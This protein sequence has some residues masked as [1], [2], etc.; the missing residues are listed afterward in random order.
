MEAVIKTHVG[1]MREVN[2]DSGDILYADDNNI[3]L[4]VVADGMGGHQA[5]DVASQMVLEGIKD[6]FQTVDK[7]QSIEAWERW[8]RET[9][10]ATNRHIYEYAQEN[11]LY[12]GMGTTV[13]A[14]LFAEHQFLVAHVGDSRLYRYTDHLEVVT[15]DHSLVH[16]LVQSG[17]ISKEEAELHPQ[18]NVIT[19]A[20]GTEASIDV[21]LKRLSYTENEQFLLCS[22]GL[23]GMVSDDQLTKVL[24]ADKSTEEKAS[25]LI[26][27]ALDAGGEDNITLILVNTRNDKRRDKK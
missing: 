15:E 3:I 17:Q 18:R 20:L 12:Q 19:R 25:T 4:A 23:N 11:R 13:V 26:Q 21:D 1:C 5:G 24:A 6:A 8:L 7:S 27:L 14:V 9:I 22:D 2:E 10:E 16:E